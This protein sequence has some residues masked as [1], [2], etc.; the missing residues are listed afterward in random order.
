MLP[1]RV[2]FSFSLILAFVAQVNAQELPRAN[3][4]ED[5]GVS[6]ERLGRLSAAIRTGVDE[7]EIPGAVVLIARKGKIAYLQSVGFRDREAGSPMKPDAIFRIAS[8][9][10]PVVSVAIM[11]LVEEGRISLEAPVAQYLPEFKEVKVGVEKKDDAGKAQLVL[12]APKR[13]MT[14]QDLLRHTSGL[15]YGF[16]GKSLVKDQYNA[17]KVLDPTQTTAEFVAKLSTLPL[18]Y[19]PGTTWE[20]S[21]STDVLGRL[22]EVVSG[23]AL[24][25]FI[26]ERVTRPLR[27]PDTAFWVEQG[28][29]HYRIAEPQVDP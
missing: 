19:H 29:Q 4:P 8:M 10:K 23:M 14:V 17:A 3:A 6:S 1:N 9:T 11:M 28:D 24:D 20:Y 7:K 25:R 15:T 21:V 2:M 5:V 12:E 27:M 22:I 16:F 26:T 13:P 18:Q